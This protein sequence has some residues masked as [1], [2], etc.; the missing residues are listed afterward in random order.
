MTLAFFVPGI[1]RPQGSKRLVRTKTG[2]TLMLD[3]D[4]TLKSWRLDVMTVARSVRPSDWPLD[5]FFSVAI[6]FRY[7]RPRGHFSAR[8]ELTAHGKRTPFPSGFDCDKLCRG[9]CDAL[10]GTLYHD[11]RQVKRLFAQLAF[12]EP[13]AFV[14]VEPIE[15]ALPTRDLA[16]QPLIPGLV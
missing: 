2:D 1:A 13:G 9:V 7:S 10:T 5:G 14:S 16:H 11:D 15:V 4:P 12:G 6:E 8:G 3:S